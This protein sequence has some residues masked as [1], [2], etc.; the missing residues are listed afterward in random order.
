MEEQS[1]QHNLVTHGVETSLLLFFI[2]VCFNDGDPSTSVNFLLPP[3][4]F[5][6]GHTSQ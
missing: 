2:L 3:L 1:V 5:T 6:F 4:L